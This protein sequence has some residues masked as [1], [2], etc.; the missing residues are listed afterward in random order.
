MNSEKF[1]H[2][3]S[4]FTGIAVSIRIPSST[5]ESERPSAPAVL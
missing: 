3:A 2:L 4:R 5:P 1:R